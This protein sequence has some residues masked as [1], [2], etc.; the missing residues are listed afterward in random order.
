MRGEPV[1]FR[2][3]DVLRLRKAH[4]CGGYLWRVTRLGADIGLNCETCGRHILL[5]RATLEKRMRTFV[6]RGSEA[7]C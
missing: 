1:E 2:L 3:E 6:E 5:D 7:I 4:P